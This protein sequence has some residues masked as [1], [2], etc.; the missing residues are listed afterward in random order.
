MNDKERNS[1]VCFRPSREIGI[2]HRKLMTKLFQTSFVGILLGTEEKSTQEPART[3]HG[4]KT[5]EVELK[6]NLG[7]EDNQEKI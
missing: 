6:R 1:S 4:Y 2:I 3:I 7:K 5:K